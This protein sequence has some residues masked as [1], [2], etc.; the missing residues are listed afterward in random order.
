MSA[1][2]QTS[3]GLYTITTVIPN[4]L[5]RN[6]FLAGGADGTKT[7]AYNGLEWV[8]GEM[9]REMWWPDDIEYSN[10]CFIHSARV[11]ECKVP[12]EYDTKYVHVLVNVPVGGHRRSE[13][14][15][16]T[17]RSLRSETKDLTF[18]CIKLR[19]D[20]TEVRSWG[21][22][23]RIWC[24][25]FNDEI[26]RNVDIRVMPTLLFKALLCLGTAQTLVYN[27]GPVT[28]V[29]THV[30]GH[31]P[32]KQERAPDGDDART[33][34]AEDTQHSART[35][36]AEDIQHSAVIWNYWLGKLVKRY[37]A[38]DFSESKV[39]QTLMSDSV[40][41]MEYTLSV[42]SVEGTPP[43]S[44]TPVEVDLHVLPAVKK[45]CQHWCCVGWQEEPPVFDLG[46]PC[47]PPTDFHDEGTGCVGASDCSELPP[48]F[49][50]GA[51]SMMP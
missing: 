7:R 29:V 49:A 40:E 21:D 13:T 14:N 51:S 25:V 27:I 19:L 47:S 33:M 32:S 5:D 46:R 23:Q 30:L 6:Y 50:Q 22:H 45:I 12:P 11:L 10:Y 42:H 26:V 17:L 15:E 8:T 2:E 48:V 16:L 38:C 3:S 43:L 24:E 20:R 1:L 41:L 44:R 39:V 37:D 9:I 34:A 18:V 35:M 28:L 31:L 36:P 4:L